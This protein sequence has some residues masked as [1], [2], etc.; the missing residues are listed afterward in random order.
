MIEKIFFKI[1]LYFT[2]TIAMAMWA[3]LAWNHYH[4][5]VPS[6]HILANEELPAISKGWGAV[7][8]PL[9]TGFSCIASKRELLATKRDVLRLQISLLG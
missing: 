3:L 8:L 6:H 2:A 9:L 7:L 4:G 1:R 5:G